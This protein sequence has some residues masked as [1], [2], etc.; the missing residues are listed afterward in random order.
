MRPFTDRRPDLRRVREVH[1]TYLDAATRREVN[2]FL[3]RAVVGIPG[4]NQALARLEQFENCHVG[5][6]PGR[7]GEGANATFESRQAP[8]QGSSIG[9]SLAA[10][11]VASRVL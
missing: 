7:E 6:E 11:S 9:R 3:D 2:E 8:F 4:G 10:V 1:T 5:C